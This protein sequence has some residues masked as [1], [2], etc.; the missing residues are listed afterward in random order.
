MNQLTP[1]EE[2]KILKGTPKGT[3][4]LMMVLAV[5]MFAGWAYMYFDMF[6]KHGPIS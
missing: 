2:Q 1:E 4:A 6:L 5:L 3:F